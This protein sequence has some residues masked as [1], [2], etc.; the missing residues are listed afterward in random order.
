MNDEEEQLFNYIINKCCTKQHNIDGM[1][2]VFHYIS[3]NK[4]KELNLVLQ[5]I[6]YRL[7]N[8]ECLLVL[9][10]LINILYETFPKE[11]A[12]YNRKL[13]VRKFLSK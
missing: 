6:K 11:M 12:N 2:K 5:K 1:N 3:E 10:G 4:A 7:E 9:Q 13:K 8:E